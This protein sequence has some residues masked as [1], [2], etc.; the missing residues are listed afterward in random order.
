VLTVACG[1]TAEPAYACPF[2]PPDCATLLAVQAEVEADFAAAVDALDADRR[3]AA[4]QCAQ[5]FADAVV[6]GACVERC[7]E[8][9]RLHPCA[10]AAR[11]DDDLATCPDRCD[12][13]VKVGV[14]DDAV[15]DVAIFHAAEAPG[16]CTCEACGSPNDPL[17]TRLFDCAPQ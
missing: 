2:V 6:D 4:G 16:F 13:L 15:L 11:R 7:D 10:S 12:V 14:I 9:C 17:C 3:A 1:R 5:L 8:L